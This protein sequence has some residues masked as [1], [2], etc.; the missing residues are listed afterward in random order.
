M[1]K[2]QGFVDQYSKKYGGLAKKIADF[3]EEREISSLMGD[4]LMNILEQKLLS[5]KLN[6]MCVEML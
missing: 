2:Y 4:D 5:R 1:S 3:M 6:F